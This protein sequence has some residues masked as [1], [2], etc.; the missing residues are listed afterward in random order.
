[1][2]FDEPT[3]Q[4]T[5][6]P[7]T[8]QQPLAKDVVAISNQKKQN[9]NMLKGVGS[10][11]AV[12]AL[13]FGVG[14]ANPQLYQVPQPKEAEVFLTDQVPQD[15][16]S[17]QAEQSIEQLGDMSHYLE[18]AQDDIETQIKNALNENATP[19]TQEYTPT[20]IEKG[21]GTYIKPWVITDNQDPLWQQYKPQN[22][23]TS[24]DDALHQISWDQKDLDPQPYTWLLAYYPSQFD[25][26]E[27][28]DEENYDKV[29]WSTINDN[30]LSAQTTERL[31]NYAIYARVNLGDE[32]FADY[33]YS[34]SDL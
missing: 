4:S 26:V 10:L 18:K 28:L 23:T 3:N 25:P 1:M 21:E 8:L 9:Q 34:N 27:V 17:D 24:S 2:N 12:A 33:V 15:E 11:V 6:S 19:L 5:Q 30:N 31:Q 20:N 32:R 7:S 14:V 22:I 29:F 13:M 16:E